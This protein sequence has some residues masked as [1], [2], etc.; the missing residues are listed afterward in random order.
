MKQR[1]WSARGRQGQAAVE[2]LVAL[3]VLILT[4]LLVVQVLWLVFANATFRVAVSY[5]LRAG[6]I[7]HGSINAME[8]TLVAAMASL[9]PLLP[10]GAGREQGPSRNQLRRA[11]LAATARQWLHYQLTGRLQIHGPTEAVLREHSERRFDLMIDD[12][13]NELP[14]DYAS[15]RIQDTDAVVWEQQRQLDIEVWWCLPLEVPLAAQVLMQLRRWWTSPAQR[16]CRLRE[17]LTGRPL[18]AM[19]QRL[20][21]PLL[22]GYREGLN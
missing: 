22:S 13:V 14:V 3:P 9:Q 7:N 6:T 2:T 4:V 19:Q 21:A 15:A 8:R 1:Q 11:Q 10:E 20:A 5:S 16:H 17:E 18:W 12:W